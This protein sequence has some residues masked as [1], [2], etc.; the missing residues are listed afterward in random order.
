MRA[1]CTQSLVDSRTGAAGP[2][3]CDAR[4]APRTRARGEGPRRRRRPRRVGVRR[5]RGRRRLGA[6]PTLSAPGGYRARGRG[7]PVAPGRRRRQ[8]LRAA[9]GLDQALPPLDAD[10]DARMPRHMAIGGPSCGAGRTGSPGRARAPTRRPR[11]ARAGAASAV[12][13]TGP[14]AGAGAS[15]AS[16]RR[17]ASAGLPFTSP[18]RRRRRK[19]LLARRRRRRRS[20]VPAEEERPR[21]AAAP[22]EERR[23]RP[24]A[25]PEWDTLGVATKDVL[26]GTGLG[27]G[28]CSG[29]SASRAR[30]APTRR[31]STRRRA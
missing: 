20:R 17:S 24:E 4:D 26:P 8:V 10:H 16:R 3:R 5:V 18:K 19:G 15:L 23:P 25:D 31:T 29:A 11:R 27:E 12:S 6:A 2:P 13:D 21:S 9:R 1:R 22:A 30:R 14:D 7:P 28:P